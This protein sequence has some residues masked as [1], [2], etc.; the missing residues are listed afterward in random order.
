MKKFFIFLIALLVG[1]SGFAQQGKQSVVTVQG[2]PH[3][4]LTKKYAEGKWKYPTPKPASG[5]RGTTDNIDFD[6][7][8]YWIGGK[9]TDSAAFLVK[10]VNPADVTDTVIYL[11]GYTW[12][13]TK[14][15]YSIDMIRAIA[16]ADPRFLVLTQ[17]TGPLGNTID[18]LGY[19]RGYT[20]R[21]PVTFN[22]AGAKADTNFSF[23]YAC[24][25]PE[26]PGPGQ[27]GI[28]IDAQGYI[29]AAIKSG[30][31]NG[32]IDHPL[33]YRY[34]YPA[35]DY[36]WWSLG[37]PVTPDTYW[38]AGW[39]LGYWSF[40]VKEGLV[41]PFDYSSLGASSRR[42]QN[43]SVDGWVYSSFSSAAADMSGEY[44]AAPLP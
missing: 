27:Y 39:Y 8:E 2:H 32:V 38:N 17:Y 24:D 42:L 33:D 34:G 21:F 40:W 10:W 13:A 44:I 22:L 4:L 35:Y 5:L 14:A 1:A 15:V 6:E 7:I 23:K 16:N 20:S 31:D 26:S 30:S 41:G 37:I 19:H 3:E 9:G 29:D 28:P 25:D 11:W 12:D 18:G 43:R 36:D